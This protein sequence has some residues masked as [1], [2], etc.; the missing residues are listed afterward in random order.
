MALAIA[1]AARSQYKFTQS[2]FTSFA[3]AKFTN[4]GLSG[5][6]LTIA[7]EKGELSA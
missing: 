6:A 4:S 7:I 5:S 1:H 3:A 2:E